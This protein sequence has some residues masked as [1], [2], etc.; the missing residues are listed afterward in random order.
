VVAVTDTGYLAQIHQTAA[1]AQTAKSPEDVLDHVW[2]QLVDLLDPQERRFEY[3][4]C[5][6]TH[7]GWNRTAGC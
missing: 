3:G 1:L 2:Q 4:S 7:R 6:V 5:S